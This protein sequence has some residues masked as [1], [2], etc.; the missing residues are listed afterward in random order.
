MVINMGFTVISP[1][2]LTTIQDLGRVGYQSVGFS[3]SGVLDY[4]AAVLANILVGNEKSEAVLEAT[5]LGPMLEFQETNII[6]ITG[7][8]FDAKIN[9]QS[10]PC[11]QAILV[12]KGD[13]LSFGMPQRGCR[14][15]IAFAGGM[16]IIEVM[17]SRSTNIRCELG[18]YQ[19][20]KLRSMDEISFRAPKA[21]LKNMEKRNLINEKKRITKHEEVKV[22][23]VVLGM[24]KDYFSKEGIHTFLHETYT[25]T[26]ESDRM[27]CKLSGAKIDVKESAD[28]ISDGVPLGGI[29]LPSSGQPIIMLNDRQ[30]TGGY[31]KIGAVCFVDIP[32]IVQGKVGESF[33][34]RSISVKKAQKLY[35]KEE[36]EYIKLV[37]Y[38]ENE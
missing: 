25:V 29:Q 11:Y 34:F 10:V 8:D 31:A 26:N 17:K 18:G 30:T 5:L 2:P 15:Y 14:C 27:G 1:G 9:D 3:T 24:Q 4:R 36:Q 37:T 35:K 16:D 19:G 21:S 28:I 6:A 23:R 7:G 22:L 32:K 38:F 13:I 20:R 12:K 33:S